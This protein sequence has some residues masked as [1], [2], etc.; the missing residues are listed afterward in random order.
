MTSPNRAARTALAASTSVIIVFGAARGL[1]RV[2]TGLALEQTNPWHALALSL[3]IATLLW[4]PLAAAMKWW[5]FDQSL[6]IRSLPLAAVNIVIPGIAFIAAQQHL[7][8]SVA[9]MLVAALPLVVAILAAVI[10]RE[11]LSRAAKIGLAA[12]TVGVLV[13]TLG[14]GGALAGSNPALG[15]AFIAVGVISAAFVYVGWRRLLATYPST[16]LLGPQLVLSTL[17]VTPL[18]LLLTPQLPTPEQLPLYASL[19]ATNFLVPQVAMFWLLT[20]TTAARAA[21]ANY[22]APLFATV[23]AIPVLGQ[24]VTPLI[25]AGGS[26]I[27]AGAVLV[28]TARK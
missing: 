6:W 4:I 13:L 3:T 14:K 9:A 26:L 25:L 21:I 7:T 27:I 28:N 2:L 10:L 12:G 22:L 11:H 16:T 15:V 23:I 8:A 18:V 17:L 24:Q 20:R 5:S 1:Q 19:G